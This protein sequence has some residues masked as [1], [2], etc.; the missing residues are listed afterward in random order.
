MLLGSR[1]REVEFEMA[2]S[3]FDLLYAITRESAGQEL[4]LRV[5]VHARI[6]IGIDATPPH[7]FIPDLHV[8]SGEH[9]LAYGD[10]YHLAPSRERILIRLLRRLEELRSGEV[11]DLKVFQLGD[12]HD[13]WR[14]AYH[15]WGE[16]TESMLERQ[17]KSH[18]D[19]FE[20]FRKLEAEGCVG[21]HDDGLRGLEAKPIRER[22]SPL[23]KLED[24]YASIDAG[25]GSKIL[26]THA[27]VVDPIEG[28]FYNSVGSRLAGT[29]PADEWRHE[30]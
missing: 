7:V 8:M 2:T 23:V 3:L 26:F 14:E 10:A 9:G 21:N 18:P 22:L 17:W 28:H 12:L 1:P 27:D 29:G 19:L 30:V 20:L 4:A 13:L 24:H 25:P 5:L 16:D 11:P 15:W 6:P